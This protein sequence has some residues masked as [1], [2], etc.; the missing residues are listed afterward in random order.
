MNAEI[1]SVIRC[2][3][4][5]AIEDYYLSGESVQ[6]FEDALAWLDAQPAAPTERWEPVE[7]GCHGNVRQRAGILY[8][9][10]GIED[11]ERIILLPAGYALC[12]RPEVTP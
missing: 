2:A 9:D 7:D 8:L 10:M 6:A 5:A 3:L 4:E 11:D 1:R 12:R